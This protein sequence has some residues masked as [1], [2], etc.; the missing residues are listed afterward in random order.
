MR[1]QKI[2]LAGVAALA[3][4]IP[5][6]ANAGTGWYLGLGAGW[7]HLE[8]VRGSNAGGAADV[9]F[10]DGVYVS[11]TAG[12][13]WDNGLR[14]EEEIGFTSH[15][16]KTISAVPPPPTLPAGGRASVTSLLLNLVYDIP[17]GDD[18][19]VSIGGGLG[20]GNVRASR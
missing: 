1:L 8:K 7:D 5:A 15:S 19:A 4:S 2:A 16:A 18:F 14:L 6:M 11:G 13:K 12:Y 3:V 10:K 20:A 17:L 9:D